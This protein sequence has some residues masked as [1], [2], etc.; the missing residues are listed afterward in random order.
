MTCLLF[1]LNFKENLP[2]EEIRTYN[3]TLTFEE[4][5]N[6]YLEYCKQRIL[7]EGTIRHY[8][9]SYLYF[10]KYFDKNMPVEDI[11]AITYKNHLRYIKSTLNNHI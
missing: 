6:K 7:R 3:Q 9:Q 1:L 2:N 8:R 11:D 4:G 10:F 5:C